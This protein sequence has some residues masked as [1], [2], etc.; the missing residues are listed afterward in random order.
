MPQ[1][2]HKRLGD[3][4]HGRVIFFLSTEPTQRQS[5]YTMK[6]FTARF[7]TG[8]MLVVKAEG[9]TIDGPSGCVTLVDKDGHFVS[10]FP[11]QNLIGITEMEA[12]LEQ[13]PKNLPPEIGS[14][15][16]SRQFDLKD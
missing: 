16:K 6:T 1:A 14:P 3:D 11:T 13:K 4:A 2:R 12:I 10:V 8:P 7:T 15:Q 5:G 9:L